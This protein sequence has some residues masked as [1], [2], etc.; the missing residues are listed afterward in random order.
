MPTETP[1]HLLI[2]FSDTVSA[3]ITPTAN[4]T[5][6]TN[7][8]LSNLAQGALD[9]RTRTPDLT[10]NA[11]LTW[12]LGAAIEHNVFMLAGTNA[13][14]TATRRLLDSNDP[15]FASIIH[16]SG[17]S[18]S[19]AIDSSV[20]FSLNVYRQPWGRLLIYI[21]PQSVTS[22]YI[23]WIQTDTDNTDG[24][25]E[26]AI[27]R[28]G[29]AYA[30]PFQDWHMAPKTQ[31]T[32]GS[33]PLR[34]HEF[35]MEFMSRQSMYEAQTLVM[36]TRG[37]RRVLAIPEPFNSSGIVHDAIWGVVHP[38]SFSRRTERDSPYQDKRY[39][40]ELSCTEVDR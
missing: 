9:V 29:M 11:T 18:M 17:P 31:Q 35:T 22:R 7:A 24:Y 13:S 2:A 33:F 23:R 38:E 34:E 15:T 27:A 40:V 26:W 20:G 3:G 21:Y 37:V 19:L 4:F 5:P 30:F 32:L 1:N 8:P 6:P 28:T 25:Q 10:A 14:F 39:R 36:A 16:E 12:D